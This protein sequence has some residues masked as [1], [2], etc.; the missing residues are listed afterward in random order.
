M[1]RSLLYF[2]SLFFCMQ[3]FS[4]FHLLS[5]HSLQSFL[6]LVFNSLNILCLIFAYLGVLFCFV[7]V[8]ILPGVFWASW[9]S[10]VSFINFGEFLVIIWFS[11]SL[12]GFLIWTIINDRLFD[13]PLPALGYSIMFYSLFSIFVS[14]SEWF[15]LTCIQIYSLYPLLC[16]VYWKS[17]LLEGILHLCYHVFHF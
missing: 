11:F 5:C 8:F 10:L 4:T 7:Y 14:Q 9:C 1:T 3:C 2:S 17:V 16:W 13:I 15:L 6:V 12:L